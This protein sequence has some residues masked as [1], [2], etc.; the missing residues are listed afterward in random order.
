MSQGEFLRFCLRTS[1][2]N[3]NS[4]EEVSVGR[5]FSDDM[6]GEMPRQI[7]TIC[8]VKNQGRF[9]NKSYQSST[10]RKIYQYSF[11]PKASEKLFLAESVIGKLPC[12]C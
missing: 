2:I 1:A 3:D 5:T 6:E 7:V 9:L 12:S 10:G 4:E 11:L 8:R